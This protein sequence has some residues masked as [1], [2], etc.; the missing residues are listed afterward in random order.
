MGVELR[1]RIKS[2]RLARGLSKAALARAVGVTTSAVLLWEQGTTS[3]SVRNLEKL[4]GAIGLTQEAFFGAVP[5]I[6][7]SAT[8]EPADADTAA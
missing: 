7:A 4:A 1:E 2:W 3:P 6:D 5:Q 8:T